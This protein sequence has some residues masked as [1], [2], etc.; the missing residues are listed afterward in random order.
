MTYLF[1][2]FAVVW[3]GLFAYL[4]G[5]VRR[6]QALEREVADLLDRAGPGPR[7]A[8]TEIRPAGPPDRTAS[9]R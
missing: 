1:W 5:L 3:I 2:A 4:Y 8:R 7:S 6:T 9:G